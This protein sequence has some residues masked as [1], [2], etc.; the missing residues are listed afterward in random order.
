MLCYAMLC[1]VMLCYV[2]LWHAML[3][4]MLY[5]YLVCDVIC[6]ILVYFESWHPIRFRPPGDSL[7]GEEIWTHSWTESFHSPP[8]CRFD[9]ETHRPVI[10]D[11]ECPHTHHCLHSNGCSTVSEF[12]HFIVWWILIGS[13]PELCRESKPTPKPTK[14]F[15]W[16]PPRVKDSFIYIFY[17]F[18][19]FMRFFLQ[20]KKFMF[21]KVPCAP[22]GLRTGWSAAHKRRGLE[23][24]GAS[25]ESSDSK[26]TSVGGILFFFLRPKEPSESEK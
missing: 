14:Y 3:C 20:D 19:F 17:L 16:F 12:P 4:Y 22:K 7:F 2:I 6:C 8:S 26:A 25:T 5:W 23:G 1:C 10:A 9:D 13:I 15:Q 24:A 18:T 11:S 21:S